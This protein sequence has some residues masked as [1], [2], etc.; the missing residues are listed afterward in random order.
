MVIALIAAG[1][2]AHAAIQRLVTQDRANPWIAMSLL[3]AVLIPLS[4][5]TGDI[6][7]DTGPAQL[8]IGLEIGLVFY[9]ATRGFL[10]IA[11]A[12]RPFATDVEHLYRHRAHLAAAVPAAAFVA[13]GEEVFWRGLTITALTPSLGT[14]G[15]AATSLL[16]F[17]L[18]GAASGSRPVVV[19]SL[20]GGTVWTALAVWPG[21]GLLAAIACHALWTVLMIVFP[22]GSRGAHR[23]LLG[24][25]TVVR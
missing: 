10:R 16:L 3:Y 25:G 19:G 23:D 2:I 8:G 11:D 7:L 5:W 1:F 4:L 22:P 21:G 12:W 20:V 9:V 15:A 17:T 13:A 18:A 6:T 24:G 14:A